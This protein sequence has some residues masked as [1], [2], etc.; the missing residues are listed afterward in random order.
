[1]AAER[2]RGW[3]RFAAVVGG[4]LA[5]AA[6][7]RYQVLTSQPLNWICE[8]GAGPWWCAVRRLANALLR[9][10]VLGGIG[11]AAALYAVCRGGPA[12]LGTAAALGAAGVLLWS[13]ELSAAAVLLVAL[14]L[15]RPPSAR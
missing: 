1:M 13:P 5:V 2:W 14:R 4:G 3:L 9:A 10:Q 12:A 6:L 8:G 15:A 11:L 7:L